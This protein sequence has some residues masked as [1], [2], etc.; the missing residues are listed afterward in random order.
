MPERAVQVATID[1]TGIFPDGL[2]TRSGT[3]QTSTMTSAEPRVLAHGRASLW[4]AGAVVFT[5]DRLGPMRAHS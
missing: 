2:T 4:P 1:P 5:A 3:C